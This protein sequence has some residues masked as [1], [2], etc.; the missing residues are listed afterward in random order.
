MHPAVIV[1]FLISAAAYFGGWNM[2]TFLKIR[3]AFFCQLLYD[4]ENFSVH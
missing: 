3:F 4:L 2:I 1:V